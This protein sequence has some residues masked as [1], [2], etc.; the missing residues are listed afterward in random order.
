MAF[1]RNSTVNLLNL[2]YGIHSIALGSGGAFYVVYLL[3]AGVPI[4]AVL[5]TLAAMMFGRF[6][7]RPIVVPLGARF[8]M[9]SLVVVGT[10]LSASQ[11]PIVAEVKGIGPALLALVVVASIADSIYWS[12]Y[13]AYFAALGDDEHRGQQIGIREAIAAVVGIVSPIAGGALLVAFGPRVAFGVTALVLTMAVGPLLFTPD[14]PVERHLPGG[15][16]AA[17][18]GM[19]LFIADGWSCAGYYFLWQMGLF[20]TLGENFLAFGGALSIAAIAGAI[21]GML[22]GRHIDAGNGSRAVVLA[23]GSLLSRLRCVLPR[24]DIR[25]LQCWQMRLARWWDVFTSQRS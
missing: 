22:L 11:Y 10:L 23:F 14:I 13:H 2:H 4:P 7:M 5:G 8:G 3:K 16:K 15:F 9:R 21:G 12:S 19:M 1:F 24:S 25:R 17:I 18:P 6:L 20:V